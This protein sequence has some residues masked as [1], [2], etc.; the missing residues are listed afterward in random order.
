MKRRLYALAG[1]LA[2]LAAP[3]ALADRVPQV[4]AITGVRIV[5]GPGQVIESGT[6]V[7]RDGLIEAVGAERRHPGRR[8]RLEAREGHPLSWP[9]RVLPPDGLAGRRQG[10]DRPRR[11]TPTPLIRPERDATSDRLERSRD[12]QAARSRLHHRGDLAQEGRPAR[13]KRARS[14][15]AAAACRD[16]LLRRHLA[17]NGALETSGGRGEG[18]P[19]S[20]M[21]AVALLRQTLY[22]ANWQVDA[23][24]AL[25]KKPA[26]RRPGIQPGAREPGRGGRRQGENRPRIARTC[27]TP[28]G[29]PAIA[30]EFGLDAVAGG[31][32]RGVQAAGRGG[33]HRLPADRAARLPQSARTSAKPTTS[34]IDLATLRHWNDAPDNPRQLAAAKIKYVFTANGLAEPKKLHEMAAQAIERGMTSR[35]GAGRLHHP[36]R[37]VARHRRPGRHPRG[38]Q[39]RQHR[40]GERRPLRQGNQDQRGFR[41]RPAL[42]GQ[43]IQE[44]DRRAGRR[45]VAHRRRRQRP[46]RRP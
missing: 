26:Q 2:L 34:P 9:D 17:Q 19:S 12:R 38:R 27:S 18:Y 24:A 23:Q 8:P 30:K 42:R 16:N 43:G 25:A 4:H 37:P 35:P 41:R 21:G 45:M 36:A 31:E 28:C 6:L 11:S 32:R 22:D 39:S 7:V 44:A 3:A 46:D 14:S 15:W 1:W 40:G 5:V 13:R 10:R 20:L 29:S 33:R